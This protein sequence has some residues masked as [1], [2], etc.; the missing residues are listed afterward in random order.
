LL[1]SY[2]AATN[3][4]R[5]TA[6]HVFPC[7]NQA[8]Y[9]AVFAITLDHDSTQHVISNMNIFDS[10]ETHTTFSN[11]PLISANSVAFFVSSFSQ[12]S[13][14]G[15]RVTLNALARASEIANTEMLLSTTERALAVVESFFDALLPASHLHLI[16]LP[17]LGDER[18][19]FYGLNYYR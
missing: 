19:S 13:V 2:Q 1:C 10:T 14:G 16:A 5:F 7:Y 11:T 6:H 18:A 9:K 3:F 8:D 17:Y 15:Q 12:S 4:R